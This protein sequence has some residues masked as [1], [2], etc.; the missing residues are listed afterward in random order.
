MLISTRTTD[1]IVKELD[2]VGEHLDD[3]AKGKDPDKVRIVLE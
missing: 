2:H 3:K 1:Q